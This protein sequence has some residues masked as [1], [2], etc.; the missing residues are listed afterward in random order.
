MIPDERPTPQSFA[1]N[2]N[3]SG[4]YSFSFGDD[5]ISRS[6]QK[7][8]ESNFSFNNK[9][10]YKENQNQKLEKHD[11]NIYQESKRGFLSPEMKCSRS[12]LSSEVYE[13]DG[14]RAM[15]SR[16]DLRSGFE[17]NFRSKRKDL[18]FNKENSGFGVA[19]SS[20]NKNYQ[21]L[22]NQR[23]DSLSSQNLYQSGLGSPRY[24]NRPKKKLREGNDKK[25]MRN[26]RY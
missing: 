20:P 7:D 10:F 13:T 6:K 23:V 15:T 19:F 17:K 21:G 12:R 1:K 14:F 11:F 22:Y 5:T 18:N 4:N 8:K 16:K 25:D 26:M 24:Q 3:S 9:S 2:G